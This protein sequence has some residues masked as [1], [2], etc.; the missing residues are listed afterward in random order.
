MLPGNKWSSKL[1]DSQFHQA[2]QSGLSGGREQ[3]ISSFKEKPTELKTALISK[4]F[5]MFNNFLKWN[6]CGFF[7]IKCE[8]A[9]IHCIFV[10]S[11]RM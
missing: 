9:A 8:V 11:T 6:R 3:G 10:T 2:T 7:H 1:E 5:L 4:D